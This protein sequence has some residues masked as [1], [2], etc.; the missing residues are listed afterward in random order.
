MKIGI[1]DRSR[2]APV[3]R[4]SVDG[5]GSYIFVDE[6][7]GPIAS[8][9]AMTPGATTID[10]YA[11][12]SVSFSLIFLL[13]TPAPRRHHEATEITK[14][15]DQDVVVR[16]EHLSAARVLRPSYYLVDSDGAPLRAEGG[17]DALPRRPSSSPPTC[18]FHLFS[19][20]EKKKEESIRRGFFLL[21]TRHAATLIRPARRRATIRSLRRGGDATRRDVSTQTPARGPGAGGP[22]G[23]DK[24]RKA[25]QDAPA[26]GQRTS[27]VDASN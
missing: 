20:R 16:S 2:P 22:K 11:K 27:T 10:D 4:I 13:L 18:H 7:T 17:T 23:G 8:Q 1:G 25:P 5:S 19:P 3:I 15:P 24:K 14:A 12:V 26:S 21:P 9:R 6:T